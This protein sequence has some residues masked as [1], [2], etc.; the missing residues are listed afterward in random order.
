MISLREAREKA[1]VLVVWHYS[2]PSMSG[3]DYSIPSMSSLGDW[4]RWGCLTEP[5]EYKNK[6]R[7]GGR[8]A[9]YH[10]SLPIQI[11]VATELKNQKSYNLKDIGEIAEDI[12]PTIIN[13]TPEASE[14]LSSAFLEVSEDMNMVAEASEKAKEASD[15]AEIEK[16]REELENALHKIERK[17]LIQDYYNAWSKYE[18][19]YEKLKVK[20]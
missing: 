17:H 7:G 13:E 1:E 16:A 8:V 15:P 14:Q 10:D 18:E 5:L 4:R 20:Q 9:L 11:A 12:V 6:G 2:V 19:R 3:W